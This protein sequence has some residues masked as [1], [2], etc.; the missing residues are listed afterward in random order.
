MFGTLGEVMGRVEAWARSRSSIR[1][2]ER[3]RVRGVVS[4]RV[5]VFFRTVG[6]VRF[7]VGITRND[8]EYTL[9][10]SGPD[11]DPCA[12]AVFT[13]A[14]GSGRFLIPVGSFLNLLQVC[15]ENEDPEAGR[16]RRRQRERRQPARAVRRCTVQPEEGDAKFRAALLAGISES[17]ET[18]AARRRR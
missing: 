11:G 10:A 1:T 18:R 5:P 16:P 17:R 4:V 15:I 13:P 9:V 3:G 2:V 8:S 12:R 7:V 14:L 6:G